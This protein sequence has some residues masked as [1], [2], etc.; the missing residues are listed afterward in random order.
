[1]AQ[2]LI[3]RNA[4][5]YD[6]KLSAKRVASLVVEN[7]RV[8][9]IGKEKEGLDGRVIECEGMVIAKPFCDYHYHL[10]GS[11]LYDLFGV[12]LC[13]CK[14]IHDYAK[15]LGEA[16]PAG[17]TVRAFGWEVEPMRQYFT[18]S[19][20]TPLQFIDEL[21]PDRP[22]IIFSLDFHSCWCNTI[23]LA[24]L[25]DE[26]ITCDFKDREIPNGAECI[27]HEKIAE[28]IF[29]SESFCFST[30][31]I[32]TAILRQQEALIA[33]GITEIYSLMFI[34]AAYFTVL[35]VLKQLDEERLLR[36]A[37][38]YA[39]TA[40]PTDTIATVKRDIARSSLYES[41]HLHLA[42]VK[43]YMDGVIDNHS[44]FL[45]EPYADT[46]ENGT[47]IW[48]QEQLHEI[49]SCALEQA[50]PLHI[51]AIGDAAVEACAAALMQFGQPARGRHVIAHVQ[52]CTENAMEIMARNNIVACMQPFWF[53]RG[54]H[55]IAVDIMRLGVR[56]YGEYPVKSLLRHGVKVLF[57]SDCPAT[58][59]CDP[60]L[61]MRTA[62]KDDGSTECITMEE[63]YLAYYAGAY[64]GESFEIKEGDRA[65]FAL[66]SGDMLKNG[67]AHVVA[68]F[69]DGNLEG[70]ALK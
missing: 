60:L 47:G 18:A 9:H 31:Q 21:F 14:T 27:L 8:V 36:I 64:R 43:I 62:V 23:A 69:I 17:K 13:A 1:M 34:G 20:K 67:D 7:G 68:T 3:F 51:H 35:K 52:L 32:R 19:E 41:S 30:A 58:E 54:Q 53:S 10:P 39:Y 44:A 55:A 57:S 28:K 46:G 11:L 65:T 49:I 56:A 66:L 24:L 50:L 6:D 2:R 33:Q 42:A 63:A 38:H 26:G 37:I 61:G 40:N 59:N 16:K 29:Q 15:A 4:S 22:A 12:N 48:T 25:K 70:G 5:L 45:A